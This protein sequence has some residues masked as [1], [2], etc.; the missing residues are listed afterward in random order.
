MKKILFT[1]TL[2]FLAIGFGKAQNKFRADFNLV[3]FYD[4]ETKIWSDWESAEH[5][6]VFNFNDNRDIVHYTAKGEVIT[7]RN[8]GNKSED[9]TN[10]NHYQIIDVLDDDGN[11]LQIQ[12]FDDRTI[13]MKII[14]G[15][16][17]VQLANN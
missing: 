10:G 3:S 15:N 13:G 17:M 5:T 16:F 8:L 9:Y 7:Y 6:L 12:L 1:L 11:Y 4:P 2:S 14:Y